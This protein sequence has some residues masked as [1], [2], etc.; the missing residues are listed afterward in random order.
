MKVL[1]HRQNDWKPVNKSGIWG[2]E[3]D[4]QVCDDGELRAR[5]DPDPGAYYSG[6]ID[7]IFDHSD[8]ERFFVDIKQNLDIKWLKRIVEKFGHRLIGLFD[9]PFP[10]AY[11]ARIA[12]LP[13]Y[14]RLSEFEPVVRLFD[15]FWVDPLVSQKYTT[16][17]RLITSTDKNHKI[18]VACP[19]L[20]GHDLEASRNVWETFVNLET[21]KDKDWGVIEGVVTKF[22]LEAM[23]FINDKIK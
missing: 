23:E 12:G 21:M 2:A 11:F 6:D 20:H 13:I 15:S 10:S 8:F 7:I 3:I 19:S 1:S 18:I 5:H 17:A 14:A 4:V 9:I 22:P 16:H